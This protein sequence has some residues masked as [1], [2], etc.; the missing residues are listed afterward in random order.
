MAT[1]KDKKEHNKLLFRINNHLVSLGW[2][3]WAWQNN[4]CVFKKDQ[5]HAFTYWSGC[6]LYNLESKYLLVGGQILFCY[7]SKLFMFKNLYVYVVSFLK[8]FSDYQYFLF[9]K[10]ALLDGVQEG[11]GVLA[12]SILGI[13]RR[14]GSQPDPTVW[15]GELTW[16]PSQTPE[17]KEKLN[18]SCFHFVS[19]LIF[20]LS[21]LK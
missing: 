4:M 12:T 5:A 8:S 11:M 14:T 6:I 16:C 10:L 9:P 2:S 7:R 15:T 20:F 17:S 18:V 3:F 13:L 1:F 19:L 21:F